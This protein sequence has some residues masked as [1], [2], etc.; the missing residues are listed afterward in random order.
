MSGHPGAW[1]K[2]RLDESEKYSQVRAMR[3]LSARSNLIFVDGVYRVAMRSS[4]S[5]LHFRFDIVSCAPTSFLHLHVRRSLSGCYQ[6][7]RTP[8]S[9][10][11]SSSA[12]RSS[13]H[14]APYPRSRSRPRW[15]TAACRAHRE[16]INQANQTQRRP[17]RDFCGRSHPTPVLQPATPAPSPAPVA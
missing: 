6:R 11:P 14:F 3:H 17:G 1:R 12:N 16:G 9:R 10:K 2:P 15:T 13:A 4:L 8:T 5:V 7:A